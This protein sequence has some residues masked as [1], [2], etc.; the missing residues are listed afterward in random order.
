MKKV[1]IYTTKDEVISL[2]LVNFIVTDPKFENCKIDIKLSN[3]S[4]LRKIKI[5]LVII[6][7]DQLKPFSKI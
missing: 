5:L 7:L 4:F 6:F 2:H 3:P 1:I